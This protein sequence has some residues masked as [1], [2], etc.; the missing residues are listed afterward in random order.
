MIIDTHTHIYDKSRGM[1]HYVQG[2][3]LR[4]AEASGDWLVS[5]MDL[6]GVDKAFLISFTPEDIACALAGLDPKDFGKSLSEEYVVEIVAKYPGRFYWFPGHVDPNKDGYLEKAES[7]L[8][9]GATGFKLCTSFMGLYPDDPKL[10]K[11]YELCSRKTVPA[12]VDYSF[13]YINDVETMPMKMH[14]K[15]Y[16]EFLK[17]VA[18]MASALPDVNFHIAH[19]G[20]PEDTVKLAETGDF[21]A[22][23]PFVELMRSHD[24]LFADTAALPFLETEEYP[25]PG[26]SRLIRFLIEEVG[27]D[28]MM[29]GTDWPY[30]CNGA[31]LTYRQG[32]NLIRQ[33]D[34]LSAEEKDKVLGG[35]ALRFLGERQ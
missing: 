33:A 18:N 17:H 25:F 29:Y 24:N 3:Y 27:T 10:M 5:S 20:S 11:L 34:Y 26:T 19:Y 32:V 6:A 21:T 13:W 1:T 28:K 14:P 35:N 15:N 31:Y 8:E 7:Y 9:R 4:H 23:A 22:L 30:F 16:A 2:F 12:I